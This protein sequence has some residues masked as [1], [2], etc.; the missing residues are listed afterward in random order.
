MATRTAEALFVA[1]KVAAHVDVA[2]LAAHR[3]PVVK[4]ATPGHVPDEADR[5]RDELGLT[6][7]RPDG[8]VLQTWM[9]AQGKERV[10]GEHHLPRAQGGARL[11]GE[12]GA[13]RSLRPEAGEAHYARD[14]KE[15]TAPNLDAWG[16]G[17]LSVVYDSFFSLALLRARALAA[18]DTHPGDTQTVKLLN[19]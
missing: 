13:V 9:G 12:K 5:L 4:D 17:P 19:S 1:W 11:G 15:R 3:R 6:Q 14:G 16:V 7:R 10:M 18:Q 2:R 8:R